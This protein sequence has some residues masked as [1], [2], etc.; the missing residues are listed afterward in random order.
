MYKCYR[1]EWS[2]RNGEP[3]RQMAERHVNMTDVKPRLHDQS[4]TEVTHS[5]LPNMG[6]KPALF[7]SPALFHESLTSVG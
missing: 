3:L 7:L 2:D 1:Y 5:I 6:I 4:V